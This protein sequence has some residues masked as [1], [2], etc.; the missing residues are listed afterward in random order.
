MG[1]QEKEAAL[2]LIEENCKAENDSFLYFLHEKDLFDTDAFAKL[3]DSINS[4]EEWKE[5]VLE[6][7]NFI[8]KEIFKHMIYHFDPNDSSQ[9]TNLPEDYWAYLSKLE[10][11]VGK[12][13]E[14]C[15]GN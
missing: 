12:Y 10:D 3:L 13:A 8:Q 6:Q 11:A 9:I 2:S 15:C 14:M 1:N 5:N 7:L 4:L